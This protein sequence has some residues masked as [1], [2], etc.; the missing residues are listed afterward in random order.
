MAKKNNEIS[1]Y[2]KQA[3][4]FLEKTGAI[5]ETEF[6]GHFEFFEDDGFTRDVYKFTISRDGKTYQSRFGQSLVNSAVTKGNHK[7]WGISFHR[8][9]IHPARV[10]ISQYMDRLKTSQWKGRKAPEAYDILACLQTY[11][12]GT[13][14]DFCMDFGYDNDS[15]KAQK[16]YFAV[17][18]EFEGLKRLFNEKELEMLAEIQ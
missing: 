10:S 5:L 9:L 13:F 14:N 6:L 18:N 11:D 12:I 8:D 15:I 16:T 3:L 4:D 1:E 7:H 17:Q 2:E